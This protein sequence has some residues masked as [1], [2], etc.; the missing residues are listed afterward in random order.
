M[1]KFIYDIEANG[2]LE[3]VTKVHCLVVRDADTGNVITSCAN[4]PG[5]S[6]ISEGL[7]LLDKADQ[8]IGH[9]I[10]GYDNPALEK[11]YGFKTKAQ[12][13]DTLVMTRLAYPNLFDRE[14]SSSKKVEELG[15]KHGSHSL[16][17]WGSRLKEAKIKFGAEDESLEKTFETWSELCPVAETS[18][19][20][21]IS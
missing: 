17:A 6:K 9:N 18:R 7:E 3:T 4:Q 11:L 5:Y 20:R 16:E 10:D 12:I 19:Q 8:L 14:I 15:H 13:F 2:L 1:N 21:I